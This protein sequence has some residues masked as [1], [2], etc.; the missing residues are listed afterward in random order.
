[1]RE[2]VGNS[3]WRREGEI[4]SPFFISAGEF[5]WVEEL[6]IWLRGEKGGIER[7]KGG[8]KGEMGGDC[9]SEGEKRFER[10]KG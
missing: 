7:E 1:M 8:S 6:L 3:K 4:F 9:S 10:R 5:P 2:W